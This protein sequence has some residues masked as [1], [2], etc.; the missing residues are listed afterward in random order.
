MTQ[1]RGGPASQNRSQA[2]PMQGEVRV[3]D[4][5]HALVKPMKLPS[6]RRPLYRRVRVPK[7]GPELANRDHTMLL[8]RQLGER[9]TTR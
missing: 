4:G 7:P 9:L 5:V 6:R 8:R 2:V 3:A 1:E